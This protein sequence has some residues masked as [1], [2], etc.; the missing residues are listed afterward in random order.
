MIHALIL[1]HESERSGVLPLD[2]INEMVGSGHDRSTNMV[3]GFL[4][5]CRRLTHVAPALRL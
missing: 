3:L 4:L 2:E 1:A 5:K